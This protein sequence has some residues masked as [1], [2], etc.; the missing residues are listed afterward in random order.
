MQVL[1]HDIDSLRKINDMGSFSDKCSIPKD[2]LDKANA[3]ATAE[4]AKSVVW[5]SWQ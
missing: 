4:E 1:Q 2:I 5:C 3:M